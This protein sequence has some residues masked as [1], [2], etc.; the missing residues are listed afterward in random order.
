MK[1]ESD[2]SVEMRIA[3]LVSR[4]SLLS[5]NDVRTAR[6]NECCCGD[7]KLRYLAKHYRDRHFNN[8]YPVAYEYADKWYHFRRGFQ[9][10]CAR[11]LRDQKKRLEQKREQVAA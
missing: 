7:R 3:D 10:F 6:T 9:N 8:Y 4:F 2:L 5:C 1:Y 11:W